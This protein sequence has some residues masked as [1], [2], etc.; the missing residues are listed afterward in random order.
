MM[1]DY[2][3]L[4]AKIV[5]LD[6]DYTPPIEMAELSNMQSNYASA[7]TLRS[8]WMASEA[9]EETERNTRE[10]LMKEILPIFGET[11]TYGKSLMLDKNDLD[12][13]VSVN[14]VIQGRKAKAAS[15]ANVPDGNGTAPTHT[16]SNARTSYA[17]R[18]GK[19]AE[20]VELVRSNP[21]FKA[22]DDKFKIETFDTRIAKLQ[23]ANTSVIQKEAVRQN[24]RIMCDNA[25]YLN[26][27]SIV[28]S[29]NSAKNYIKS[30]FSTRHPIWNQIKNL[31]F[32]M[33]SRLL[34][35]KNK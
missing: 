29:G 7:K 12:A 19:A 30:R 3:C 28:N 15:A 8:N 20:F 27:D 21:K 16:R 35:K 1:L 11:I 14:R 25:L 10:D 17:A 5:E 23:N 18:T 26:D 9:D 6:A 24:L 33:P 22:T 13:L 34:K 4:M 2:E 32:Q 31:R